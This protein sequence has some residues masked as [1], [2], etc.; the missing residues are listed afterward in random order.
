MAWTQEKLDALLIA[1]QKLLT[2]RAVVEAEH[3]SGRRV[4]F[5]QSDMGNLTAAIREAQAELGSS[6]RRR[7]VNY[8]TSKGV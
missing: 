1:R 2:G 4:R 6:T 7:F 5:Q 3:A 8:M